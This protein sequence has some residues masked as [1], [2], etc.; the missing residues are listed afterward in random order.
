VIRLPASAVSTFI[1][2]CSA[3]LSA[4]AHAQPV[5]L[6]PQPAARWQG[7]RPRAPAT[8]VKAKVKV[9]PASDLVA[10]VLPPGARA[11]ILDDPADGPSSPAEVQPA[12]TSPSPLPLPSPRAPFTAAG[13]VATSGDEWPNPRPG[14]AATYPAPPPMSM[15]QL[16]QLLASEPAT[17]QGWFFRGHAGPSFAHIG[18]EAAG[19]ATIVRGWGA[20]LGLSGGLWLNPRWVA[21]LELFTATHLGVDITG[22]AITPPIDAATATLLAAGL[23]ASYVLGD[24]EAGDGY[25]LTVALLL[26]RTRIVEQP[27][28][29]L[30][31]G[32]G[33]G[34]ALQLGLTREWAIVEGWGIGAG[35]R[36][37]VGSAAD[38][39]RGVDYTTFG[40]SFSFSASYD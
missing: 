24:H 6:P 1:L 37:T 2:V 30:L 14:S 33:L 4:A 35:V 20:G 31:S 9:A 38:S 12:L 21:A 28:A 11:P 34:P 27:S 3:V 36:L 5:V 18:L 16:D 8:P 39:G 19:R 7:L 29:Q 40:T 15:A 26:T 23:S 10:P 22:D 25:S 17:R 13:V 32:S